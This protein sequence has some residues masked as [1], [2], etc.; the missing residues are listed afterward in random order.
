MCSFSK[1]FPLV[2]ALV[3]R[4]VSPQNSLVVILTL[5]DDGIR[6]WAFG[7]W[8]GHD[9]GALTSGISAFT[10]KTPQ[11]SIQGLS[12]HIFPTIGKSLLCYS[13][14]LLF[15]KW[16]AV[17]EK[18]GNK[19]DKWWHEAR[20]MKTGFRFVFDSWQSK[21]MQRLYIEWVEGVKQEVSHQ[22]SEN[23]HFLITTSHQIAC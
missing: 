7:R 14:F 20:C 19:A 21:N 10:K 8:L 6:W 23:T 18:W 3:W 5:K 15:L 13:P 2:N 11:R 12:A 1:M 16:K 9:N 22:D 17:I 4:F